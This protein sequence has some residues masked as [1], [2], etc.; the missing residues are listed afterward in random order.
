VCEIGGAED[1]TA[2]QQRLKAAGLDLPHSEL[3][4]AADDERR[5]A[6]LSRFPIVAR[7]SQARLSYLLDD[8]RL[9]V[10]RG[11]LDVT[12]QITESY[13]LRCLGAHLKSRRGVPEANEGLMRRNEAHLLRRYA[14]DILTRDPDVNLLVYGDFNDTRE[15]AAIRAVQGMRG[16]DLFLTPLAAEDDRGERWT[17]YFQET[18]TYSRFDYLLASRALLPETDPKQYRIPSGPD[19]S[20]ASDHRPVSMVLTPVDRTRRPR[21]PP[22]K[23]TP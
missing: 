23:Q 18:D 20:G 7:Q 10:Q 17:H 22:A 2:L 4:L 19:W 3:V 15:Q 11:F 13:R 8:T 21:K 12:L 14:E 6:L 9:P 1:V 16:S 5:L